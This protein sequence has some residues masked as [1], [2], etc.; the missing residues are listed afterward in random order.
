MDADAIRD[1]FRALGP[2]RIRKMF[3]GQGIYL[4]DL[5]FA[6]EAGGEL[7]L[8]ADAE[9]QELFRNLGSRPFAYV[10]RDGRTS[11]MSYWLIPESALD[12]PDEA[13]QLAGL[14]VE[15]ARRAKVA[16]S[17]KGGK[18]MPPREA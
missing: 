7:H 5:M 16:G 4:G 14:A 12:D 1:V 3:G 17:R 11:T 8:K 10:G 13:A 18:N 9:T 2:V 6:L 15:A